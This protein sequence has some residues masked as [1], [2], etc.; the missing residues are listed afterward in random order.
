L[1]SKTGNTL[2]ALLN[3]I[4]K[5]E[6]AGNEISINLDA[7]RQNSFKKIKQ[8]IENAEDIL[9]AVDELVVFLNNLMK[10]E[11]G[12]EK[13]RLFLDWLRSCRQKGGKVRW[14]FCS[15]VGI[16]N[17]AS[18]HQMSDTLN[19]THRFPLG[20]FPENEAKEFIAK[21][22]LFSKVTLSE[23]NIQYILDKLSWYLP[24]FIQILVEKVDF[25]I[26]VEGKQ[27]SNA[28][29]DEAYSQLIKGNDFN[30]WNERL[31][32]YKEFEDIARKI[33]KLCTLPV[34]RSRDDLLANL[35]AKKH[36]TEKIETD[37]S[38]TLYMLQNDGYLMENNGKYV[39]RSPLLRDF[40]YNR[41]IL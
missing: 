23:A 27:L 10:Q 31:K 7:W 41:F 21:L 35:S 22:D 9:I 24:Y 8:L 3:S 16:E 13:V 18:M 17:F 32:Y 28:A 15:S 25:L 36:N 1:K 5:L 29:I 12:K 39:F 2:T 30:T 34:G 20:A 4:E 37:L 26:K 40:W 11:N 6:I 19:D 33:L 14:V 38:K